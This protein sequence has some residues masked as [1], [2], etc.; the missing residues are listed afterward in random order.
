MVAGATNVSGSGRNLDTTGQTL[1]AESVLLRHDGWGDVHLALV[2]FVLVLDV[3][4]VAVFEKT[5]VVGAGVDSLLEHTIIPS[6]NEISVVTGT[7][8]VT[9]GDDELAVHASEWLGDPDGLVEESGEAGAKALGTVTAVDLAR[10][11]DVRLVVLG[12][13]VLS[14][15][16]R[17]EHDL[18]TETVCTGVVDER[19]LGESVS[20]HGGLWRAGVVETV[21]ADGFLAQSRLSLLL[22]GPAGLWRIRLLEGEVTETGI[23]RNHTKASRECLDILSIQEVVPIKTI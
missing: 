10:I 3:K 6:L 5:G 22:L 21:E 2:L 7:S 19:A 8:W 12:V 1:G 15:P 18:K 11:G 16:A 9:V 13:E 4:D 14:V 20:V 17:W 23:S